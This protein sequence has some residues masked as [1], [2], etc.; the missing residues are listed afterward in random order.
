MMTNDNAST[1]LHIGGIGRTFLT[2]IL[3]LMVT[4]TALPVSVGRAQHDQPRPDRGSS[5]AQ[6]R[7]ADP[8]QR[9]DGD[10]PAPGGPAVRLTLD[11]AV[12]RL[13]RENLALAAMRLEVLQARADIL[14]A[15]Q[16]P[17]SLL[18]I[19]GGKD[20]PVRLRLLDVPPKP[21]VRALAACVAVRVT[22]AQYRDAVRTRTASLYTT[23]VD[24]QEAQV[25]ARFARRSV[26]GVDQLMKTTKL[27]AET[28]Q[29]GKT[30]LGRTAAVQARKTLAA[31]D[32]EVALRKTRLTL[33][34]L[35]NL[36]DA[37]AEHFEV[38]EVAEERELPLPA[39]GELTRLA[40][41]HRPDLHAHRLG[42]W[43][44]V[45]E[46]LRA[47]VEQWP[48]LYIVAGPNRPGRVDAGGMADAVPRASGLLVS[49][50]DSGHYRGRVVRAQIN[51]AKWRIELARV[52]RQIVLDVRQAH[53]EYTHSLAAWRRLK[54]EV[55]PSAGN[56]R[57]EKHRLFQGEEV[58]IQAYLSAQSEYNEV[59]CDY[60]K[61]AIR[62]R[63]AA[64]ALNTAVG[65]RVLPE[66]P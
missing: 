24:V 62:H 27:L 42:F 33:A 3:A 14:S 51:V 36:S 63:R 21:W 60:V 41:D 11:Q 23:Y 48:D 15:G 39:L 9:P 59:V 2:P 22:E 4:L 50:P 57:D 7:P 38:T 66:P 64:L 65:K 20:G 18:F 29:I 58:A 30:D 31:T 13:E 56:V 40:F 61:A 53:L 17:N 43:R 34:D 10:A 49:F 25:Q 47:W 44:S 16:R 35:L 8:L 19:G 5:L 1:V 32:A 45:A 26:T 54:A 52:E 6:P 55:L 28:G 37:D 46:W 12:D